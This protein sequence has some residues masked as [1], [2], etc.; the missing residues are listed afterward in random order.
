[1]RTLGEIVENREVK[2]YF[3]AAVPQ[4]VASELRDAL[5]D[6]AD[7]KV[8]SRS[9]TFT[10]DWLKTNGLKSLAAI[11]MAASPLA[12]AFLI[13][14]H[15]P[16]GL[17]LIGVSSVFLSNVIVMYVAAFATYQ[18][19]KL[20]KSTLIETFK[21]IEGDR[22]YQRWS[23]PKKAAFVEFAKKVKGSPSAP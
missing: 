18:V 19:A 11:F 10:L 15:L 9:L 3:D 8:R 21:R 23:L 5:R 6:N 4:S 12:T 16:L 17:A 1:M 13:T 14:V 20:A 22:R 7:A 2:F